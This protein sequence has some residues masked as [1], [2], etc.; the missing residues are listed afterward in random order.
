MKLLITKYRLE[1]NDV[2]L[3]NKAIKK[4]FSEIVEILLEN[5][6]SPNIHTYYGKTSIMF[7]PK[8]NRKEIFDLYFKKPKTGV[9][10]IFKWIF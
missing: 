10:G 2:D 8:E 5:G 7:K 3:L 9:K 4:G 6:I 1:D